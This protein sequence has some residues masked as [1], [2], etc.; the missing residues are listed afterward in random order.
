MRRSRQMLHRMMIAVLAVTA[1]AWPGAIAGEALVVQRSVPAPDAL[2]SLASHEWERLP[3]VARLART[4]PHARVLLTQPARPNGANCYRCAERLTWLQSL[5]TAGDRV[6]MLPNPVTNTRD[7]AFAVAAYQ[8]TQP[9]RSLVVVTSPYHARRAL[10]VF[11]SVLG[12]T[13]QLGIHPASPHSPA[14][15]KQWWRAAYDRDYVAY[16]WAALAWYAVRYG[17]SPMVADA[18][19]HAVIR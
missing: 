11:T 17:I 15:P 16:E 8:H 1:L 14:R 13:V 10:A 4:S 19:E 7:E 5:G 2:V 3:A 9:I 18:A 6:V 12:R